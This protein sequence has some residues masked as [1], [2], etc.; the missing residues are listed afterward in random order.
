[1]VTIPSLFCVPLLVERIH[2]RA[3]FVLI[4][5]QQNQLL[6]ISEME[7]LLIMNIF[8]SVQTQRFL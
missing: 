3:R 2:V 8:S 6:G 7:E 4:K 1:M 5:Q